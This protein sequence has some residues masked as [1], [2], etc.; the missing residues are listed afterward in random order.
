MIIVDKIYDEYYYKIYNWVIK[1]NH[2][3]YAED[4]TNSVFLTITLYKTYVFLLNKNSE[5][6][7]HSP[8]LFI[9]QSFIL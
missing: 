6:D 7:L 4:L 8:I 5:D 1:T 9:I 3:E 2:T